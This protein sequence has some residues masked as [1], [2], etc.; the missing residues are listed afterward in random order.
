MRR[1]PK[2]PKEPFSWTPVWVW[3]RYAL[4]ESI[5]GTKASGRFTPVTLNKPSPALPKGIFR[6]RSLVEIKMPFTGNYSRTIYIYLLFTFIL[7]VNILPIMQSQMWASMGCCWW[8]VCSIISSIIS[9]KP[10]LPAALLLTLSL[11]NKVRAEV[12]LSRTFHRPHDQF[13]VRASACGNKALN[14]NNL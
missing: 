8:K 2:N 3:F 11:R 7:P 1:S 5:S 14:N 9:L 6:G 4:K 10:E 13:H 12:S